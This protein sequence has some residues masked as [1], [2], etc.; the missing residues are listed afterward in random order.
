[1]RARTLAALAA[2]A[3]ACSHV[4]RVSSP[5]KGAAQGEAQAQQPE[6]KRG[7]GIEKRGERPPV[8]AS[9]QALLAPDAVA[10]IQDALAG[11]GLLREHRPG[12]LDAATSA[13]IEK[14]QREEHL[15]STGFP[16]RET[17]Q[18]LGI[19]PSTAYRSEALRK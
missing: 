12:E 15:A 2:S 13:A 19:D 18:R 11:R 6:T 7:V 14:F 16:D 5:A 3:L 9:P 1:M 17:L 4:H 10:K 8:P